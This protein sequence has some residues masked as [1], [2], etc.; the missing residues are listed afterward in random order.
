MKAFKFIIPSLLLVSLG[1]AQTDSMFVEKN[2]GTIQRYPISLI[3]ELSFSVVTEV[4]ELSAVE[5][6][7]R[8]FVLRQNY[9]NPFNPST[10]IEF[11][12][13]RAG[14]VEVKIFDVTGR[15]V[16]AILDGRQQAGLHRVTWDGHTDSGQFGSSGTY[17][18]QVKFDKS[19]LVKKL[20]LIK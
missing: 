13:P 8:S 3:R 2:D 19:F 11:E 17:L 14:Y 16:R 7:L 5:T 18:C 9:P 4:K 15:L 10:T 1:H 6:I 12:I 20:M